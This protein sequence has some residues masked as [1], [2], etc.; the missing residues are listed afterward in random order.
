MMLI[1][2]LWAIRNSHGLSAISRV[3]ARQRAQRLHHRRLQ[4]VLGIVGVAED[5]QAIPI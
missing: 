5:R 1:A 4:R 3:L 2:S